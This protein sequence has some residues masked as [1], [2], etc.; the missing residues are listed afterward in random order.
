MNEWITMTVAFLAGSAAG[1]FFVASL[2]WTTA[3]L[4]T[5]RQPWLLFSG[6]A[7]VRLGVV[8]GVLAMLARSGD[9]RILI[10]GVI[11]FA[12]IRT[13]G[14]RT[15]AQT[16]VPDRSYTRQSVDKDHPPSGDGSYQFHGDKQ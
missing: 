7:V 11:G 10:A 13:I 1:A 4:P 16:G 3:R 14:V 8:L 15:V 6:S 2:W 12:L 5:S 9:W